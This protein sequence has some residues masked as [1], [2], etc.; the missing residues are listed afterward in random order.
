MK[1]FKI[2]NTRVYGLEESIIAS[3]YPML[4]D[5]SLDY[6]EDNKTASADKRVSKLGNA[7]IGSG[8]DSFLKGII[9]QFDVSYPVYWSPQFQRYHFADIVSSSSAMHRIHTLKLSEHCMQHTDP[10]VIAIVQNWIDIYNHLTTVEGLKKNEAVR[11]IYHHNKPVE[12]L[13]SDDIFKHKKTVMIDNKIPEEYY[14]EETCTVHDV[15]LKIIQSCPQGLT[16][17]MRITTNYLQLK[18]IYS[19][20]RYHKLDETWGVM[21]NWMK[22]LERFEELCLGKIFTK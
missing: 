14:R 1:E 18:T 8:H 17:T 13:T 9:V 3:G 15:Y 21:C 6:I 4:T 10:G 7:E 12:V 16:K 20:R 5:I 22:S 2:G 19:Q 11:I